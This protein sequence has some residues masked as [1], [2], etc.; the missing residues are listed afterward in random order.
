MTS[1][2]P[3]NHENTTYLP[4]P[5]M[6]EGEGGGEHEVFPFT[7]A[8]EFID[9]IRTEYLEKKK[10]D[11]RNIPAIKKVLRGP[12]LEDIENAVV[13][14]LGKDHALH[15]KMSIYLIHQNSGMRLDEI[16]SYFGMKGSAVSQLS[17]RF[18][19]A[20]RGDKELGGIF[21]KIKKEVLLNVET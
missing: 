2:I 4:S 11:R 14:V 3:S 8:E 5:L 10:I 17:R 13:K 19:E 20:I 9:W 18:K 6:G 21:S 16:G 1:M 7:P 12:T 15:K